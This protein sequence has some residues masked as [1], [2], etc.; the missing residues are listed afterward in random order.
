MLPEWSVMSQV[1]KKVPSLDRKDPIGQTVTVPDQ[2]EARGWRSML[3]LLVSGRHITK[4]A[5]D[6]IVLKHGSEARPSWQAT[7]GESNRR[8]YLG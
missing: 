4:T 7:T 5:A 8:D 3:A 2:M 6:K 1:T